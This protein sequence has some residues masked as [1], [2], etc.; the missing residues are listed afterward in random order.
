MVYKMKLKSKYYECML[1]GTKRIEIRLYDEKRKKIQLGDTIEFFKLPDLQ[2]SFK[3]KVVGL[4]RYNS[5]KDMLKDFD[6]AVLAD[7]S[8]TKEELTEVFNEIYTKE[9]QEKYGVLGISIDF[10]K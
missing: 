9:D 1:K 4:L 10:I 8:M 6:V 2:D 5:L 3:V 7:K